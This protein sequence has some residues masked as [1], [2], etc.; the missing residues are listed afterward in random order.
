M[1]DKSIILV[2]DDQP[3]NIE[4]LEAH[5]VPQGYEVVTAASGDEALEKISTHPIDLILLDVTM[6]GMNGFDVTRSVRQDKSHW[7]I[8]IILVTALRETEDRVRGIEAGCDDFISK[9]VDKL[10]L[11]AR[12]RSLLKVKGYNDLVNNY[13]KELESEVIKRTRELKLAFDNLQK[14]VVERKRTEE[15]LRETSDYLENL[16]SFTNAL[17]MVWDNSHKI[18]RFNLTFER[19]SG[20]TLYNVIGKHPEILFSPDVRNDFSALLSRTSDGENLLPVELPVL[21]KDGSTRMVLWNTANIYTE[22]N[23]TIT[24]TIAHGQDITERKRAETHLQQSEERYRRLVEFSPNAIL[25]HSSGKLVYVNP[26]AVKL[27]GAHDASD[28]LGKPVIDF[29]HPD[30]KESERLRIAPGIIHDAPSPLIEEKFLRLDGEVVDVEVSALSILY[31][32]QP[33]IQ[34]VVRDITEQKKTQEELLQSLKMQSIGTIAGGVAHDF[35]NILAIILGY[36]SLIEKNNLNAGKQAEAITAINQAVQRGAAL[37]RQILTFARKTDVT[38]EPLSLADLFRELFSMLEQTFPKIIVFKKNIPKDTPYILAD[39]TQIYQALLNLCVNARDA[40]PAGGS[41]TINVEKEAGE[42]LKEQFST[43]DQ[44]AYICISVTDTGEGMN[45]A[46]R[47]RIFDPFFTTKPLGKGTGLGLSVVYGVV[48]A[49]HGFVNVESELGHGTTFRLYFPC[50]DI[51]KK[52]VDTSQVESYN[53]GGTEGI[54]LVEDEKLLL[55]M[56]RFLLESKG[57]KVFNARDGAEAIE[58]YK[59]HREEI[60]LVLT[61]M[62]LP[63]MVGPEVFKKLKEINPDVRIIMASGYFE[64]DM[65]TELLKAGAMDFLQKP[66]KSDNILMTIRKSLDKKV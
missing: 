7:Q 46:T 14:E 23:K 42:K 62:G 63:V 54:L 50:P 53:I 58:V 45:E 48:K 6:P 20:Y 2:V 12:V 47:C 36:S 55:E 33:A 39:R 38:F 17:I 49:H 61:D 9:P 1:K 8:P 26:A 35:N 10:E 15:T 5:L 43:A 56:T 30:N 41:I 34:D 3:Q 37:V 59:A 22:D 29:V 24:A 21:C 60:A 40:M 16:F 25:V 51:I 28:L 11:L 57:Y 32:G 66:Y 27:L 64:P 44:K 65:K 13:R 31:D 19:L 52:A 4:L 18:T